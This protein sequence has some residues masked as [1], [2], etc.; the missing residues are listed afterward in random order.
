MT[1]ASML[2]LSMLWLGL[3][4]GVFAMLAGVER[5]P[6][7]SGTAHVPGPIVS[8]EAL[9]AASREISARFH[10]PAIAAFATVFG[11]VGY[12]LSRYS[13]LGT[14]WQ[15]LIATLAGGGALAGAVALI[16]QWAI[17]AARRDVPDERYL[18]QGMLAEVT[19][20]IESRHAGRIILHMNG[21]AH[22][23]QAVSVSG[24]SIPPGTEVV[25]ERIEGE[26][27]FVEPWSVVERRL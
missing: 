3:M 14:G 11:A 22:A 21:M 1:L 6:R 9:A 24:D 23:V 7:R 8:R 25:I 17:P 20:A 2:F 27:A 19:D 10:V 15:L 4:L 12:P 13:G 16:A 18:L 5:R 26:T